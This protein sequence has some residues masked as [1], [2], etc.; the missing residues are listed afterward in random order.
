MTDTANTEAAAATSKIEIPAAARD[1]AARAVKTAQERAEELKSMADKA[2]ARIESGLGVASNTI[3]DASRNLQGAIYDDV[4]SALA[5]AEKIAAAK[6]LAEAAQI[7]V[8]YLGERSQI[9]FARMAKSNEYFARAL[10]DGAKGMQ[11]MIGNLAAK[12]S[13]AA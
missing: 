10:Q 6:S 12:G 3:A 9:G 1:L 11:S 5:A 4:K 8:Q 13:R 7:H 2:T